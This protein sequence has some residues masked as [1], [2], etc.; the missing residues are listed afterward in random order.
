MFKGKLLFS[1]R[2][3]RKVNYL[4]VW[5]TRTR[6]MSKKTGMLSG[7][8]IFGAKE[9][10]GYINSKSLSFQSISWVRIKLLI[11]FFKARA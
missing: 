8:V 1:I 2:L 3:S 10:K 11:S 6:K 9:D 4:G 5:E 7:D